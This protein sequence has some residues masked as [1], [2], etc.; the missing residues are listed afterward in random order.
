MHSNMSLS[1]SSVTS[2]MSVVPS[3]YMH[4]CA[5]LQPCLSFIAHRK[6]TALI[7]Q[8]WHQPLPWLFMKQE[9]KEHHCAV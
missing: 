7:E 1:C 2:G 3:Q 8:L 6:A 4:L 5:A 9:H